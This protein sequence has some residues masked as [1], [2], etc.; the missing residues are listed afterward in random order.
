MKQK[1]KNCLICNKKIHSLHN[2]KV[3]S[4]CRDEYYKIKKLESAK[5]WYKNNIGKKRTYDFDLRT[6]RRNKI[7]KSIKNKFCIICGNNIKFNQENFG[8]R[9]KKLTCSEEC[10]IKY[11]KYC[12]LRYEKNQYR[13]L[14]NKGFCPSCGKQVNNISGYGSNIYCKKC[15][16]HNLERSRKYANVREKRFELTECI[17]CGIDITDRLSKAKYCILCYKDVVK[18]YHNYGIRAKEAV[19]ILKNNKT[20]SDFNPLNEESLISVKRES[21]DSPNSPH[22]SSTIKEEANFS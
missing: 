10:K 3:C 9:N 20:V 11:E 15:H 5:D 14:T 1:N 7:L 4:S 13:Q 18:L 17:I 6:K 2:Q 22:D 8:L 19:F 16:K 12:K 21:A